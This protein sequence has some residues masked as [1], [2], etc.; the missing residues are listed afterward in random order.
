MLSVRSVWEY[1]SDQAGT[2]I[3]KVYCVVCRL[4]QVLGRQW[5]LSAWDLAN[6]SH[7]QSKY[8]TCAVLSSS[9]LLIAE[10]IEL[11]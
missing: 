3:P 5:V 8:D 10:A 11:S 1:F 7:L 2:I 9:S 4:S 6:S